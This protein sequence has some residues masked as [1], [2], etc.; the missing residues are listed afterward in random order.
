MVM[1]HFLR[2]DQRRRKQPVVPA[3]VTSVDPAKQ[4]DTAVLLESPPPAPPKA[5]KPKSSPKSKKV[6]PKSKSHKKTKR[7][8]H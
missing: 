1:R 7:S 5:E 8:A 6:T 3:E 2:T 4:P